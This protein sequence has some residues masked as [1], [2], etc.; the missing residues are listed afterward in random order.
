M[1]WD[2]LRWDNMEWD[3]EGYSLS[4]KTLRYI[5][6][7]RSGQEWFGWESVG[8]DMLRIDGTDGMRRGLKR[9]ASS[10]TTWLGLAW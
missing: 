8:L 4:G 1:G 2:R 10:F 6:E 3:Q 5:L 7:S 9:D